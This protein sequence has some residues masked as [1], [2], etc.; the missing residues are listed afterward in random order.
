MDRSEDEM[1]VRRQIAAELTARANDL[2]S[3][4]AWYE[5]NPA[6]EELR[7]SAKRIEFPDGK[8]PVTNDQ[9]RRV[10]EVRVGESDKFMKMPEV[11]T[12]SAAR[13]PDQFLTNLLP[14]SPK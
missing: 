12:I 10:I 1:R 4:D 8:P 9:Y 14:A 5:H 3:L 13:L 2:T 11:F 6:A 7:K